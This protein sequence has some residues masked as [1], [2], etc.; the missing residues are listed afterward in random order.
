MIEEGGVDEIGS[1]G[2]KIIYHR[3][4]HNNNNNN[5][6]LLERGGNHLL[7]LGGREDY[8][9][10]V[11]RKHPFMVLLIPVIMIMSKAMKQMELEEDQTNSPEYYC[12]ILQQIVLVDEQQKYRSLSV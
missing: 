5:R 12:E 11:V 1:G 6:K 9:V 10:M 4:R 8:K 2:G 7:S 3:R